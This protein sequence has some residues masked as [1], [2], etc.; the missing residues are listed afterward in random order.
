MFGDQHNVEIVAGDGLGHLH[1]Q[2]AVILSHETIGPQQQEILRN[3]M[4][5]HLASTVIGS[6]ASFDASTAS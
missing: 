5:H 4:R 3:A 6:L 1:V 2:F